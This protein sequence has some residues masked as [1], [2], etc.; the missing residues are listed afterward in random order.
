[1]KISYNWLK[2]YTP[3]NVSPEEAA[4]TLTAT[5]LEVEGMERQ[6]EKFGNIVIGKVLA[7]EKHPDADK[8]S[9]CTV[10]DGDREYPVICGAPNVAEGQ[11]VFFARPGAVLP[12]GGLTIEKR[13]IRGIVSEGMIC[14]YKELG[15]SDDHSGIAV[16]ED[17]VPLGSSAAEYLGQTDT[18][19]EIGIT[20]NRMDAL[21]HV[22]VAR[23]LAA[24]YRTTLSLPNPSDV[25]ETRTSDARVIVEDPDLCPRYCAGII[26]GITVK[27]SP[28]WLRRR[29]LAAGMRPLN[30][31][32]D[33]TNFVML[34]IGQPMHAF[35]LAQIHGHEIRVR[36]AGTKQRFTTL[37]DKE[38][39]IRPETL[40]I[41][42][43]DRSLAIAGVMGGENSEISETTTDILLES[44]Y[45]HPSSIRRTSK[46]LGLSTESSYR[47]ERGA[48]PNMIDWALK[49]AVGL[50]LELAGGEYTGMIDEYPKKIEPWE[51]DLRLS[52]IERIL[53]LSIAD[54]EVQGILE[55]LGVSTIRRNGIIAC[56]VP[57]FKADVT[58]E[59][60]LIEEVARIYGY[61]NI[62]VN[63]TGE[64]RYTGF[65]DESSFQNKLRRF[66][67]GIGF[68]ETIA[69]SLVKEKHAEMFSDRAVRLLNPV[70]AERPYLRPT[71]AISMLETV[72]TNVHNGM[73][74][75]RIFELG[76]VFERSPD[77]T[78]GT[79]VPGYVESEFLGVAMYGTVTQRTWHEK[80]RTHDFFD[81]KG[82]LTTLLKFL[83]LDNVARIHYCKD[84]PLT[85]HRF[86]VEIDN[87]KSGYIAQF[88]K[89]VL[90][91]FDLEQPVYYL[92]LDM[93]LLKQAIEP[94]ARSF[95][96]VSKYPAVLRDVSFTFDEDQLAGEVVEAVRKM[97]E[98]LVRNIRVLD[99]FQ[100]ES[101][102]AGK[103]SIAFNLV[104][105]AD[106][107]TL[108]DDEITRVMERVIATVT[109]SFSATLR[110]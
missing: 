6:A 36:R 106:D 63:D 75:V 92:E 8:L 66:L 40:M 76:H 39:V 104:L 1:M 5:G 70:N 7:C 83:H 53:G 32:V 73:P 56:K 16:I 18:I 68:D 59:I 35:D 97:K 61:D 2:E 42:D 80:Q 30:N 17:D 23:D 95:I 78:E 50:I 38:R 98:P 11:I 62:P 52:Q 12:D 84:D 88:G 102:G 93:N 94:G 28:E 60:D 51:V 48:D 89:K 101:L 72:A 110:E 54:D 29:L 105:Q 74:G 15:V 82:A 100:H 79:Y 107:H 99:V 41:C 22:G 26:K 43:A 58:R 45:F 37:D 49:R 9:V 21:S 47:F 85:E 77:R 33:I 64:V 4:E 87:K 46:Y 65:F 81:I 25:S 69:V 55:R 13:K 20:P 91:S 103:K 67:I 31:I 109:R 27:E 71:L 96:P 57:T 14:S 3:I 44:A 34:E 24:V 90:E 108:S 10:S 19:F 86:S